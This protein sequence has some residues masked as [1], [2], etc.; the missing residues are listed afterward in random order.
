MAEHYVEVERITT[1]YVP[2]VSILDD[3]TFSIGSGE[4]TCILGPSGCGKSTLLT[5]LSGLK[6]PQSGRILVDG[7][8]IYDQARQAPPPRLGYVFQDHRLLPWR[9]VAQNISLALDSA[10]VPS[11]QHEEI[12]R[13]YL[14]SLQIEAFYDSWPLRLSGGQR[15][16]VAI[17]RAMAIDPLYLLMDEPFSTL[18]E[19]TARELR[20]ELLEIWAESGK[21]VVFV[22][23]SVH[24]ALYLADR[25]F[26]LTTNPGRLYRTVEVTVP[27]KRSHEDVELARLEADLIEDLLVEWG[28][29][30]SQTPVEESA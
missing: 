30:E 12:T 15:Q 1:G 6:P 7:V 28:S 16:R 8:D 26:V 27:R 19:L 17:A 10:G 23:H 25:V 3:V 18:D 2:G 13:K 4:F 20:E 21:T 14:R 29:Q 5:T 24:E 11:D 9:T 22:T